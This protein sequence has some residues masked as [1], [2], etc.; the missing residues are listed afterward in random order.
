MLMYFL[1]YTVTDLEPGEWHRQEKE[2]ADMEDILTTLARQFLPQMEPEE[3][4]AAL[5]SLKKMIDECYL[6]ESFKDNRK[7]AEC[8]IPRK[9]HHQPHAIDQREQI[10]VLT[11]INDTDDFFFEMAGR[12][13]ITEERAAAYLEDKVASGAIV[14]TDQAKAYREPL[15]AGT[16]ASSAFPATPSAMDASRKAFAVRTL[17]AEISAIISRI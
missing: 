7:N 16:G 13:N 4:A 3:R 1:W 10:C 11:G 5:R 15:S 12:G 6:R 8:G 2:A 14:S 9:V 17:L